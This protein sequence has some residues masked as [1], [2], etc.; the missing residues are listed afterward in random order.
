MNNYV[1][2]IVCLVF[3]KLVLNTEAAIFTKN[4]NTD[5]GNKVAWQNGCDFP[6]Q[7]L[8]NL[9]SRPE[10]CGPYCSLNS[11]CTHFTWTSYNG[12]TCWLKQKLSKVSGFPYAVGV[13][14]VTDD[15][16][17]CGFMYAR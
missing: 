1:A 6:N 15:S 3:I 9:K 7:N 5:A 11:A 17:V 2:T 13:F 8:E 10:F 12:G 14:A 4:W 16:Y